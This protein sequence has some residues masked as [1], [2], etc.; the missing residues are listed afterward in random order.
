MLLATA[1]H[2]AMLVYLDNALS[3]SPKAR[4]VIPGAQPGINE[5]YA[6]ELLELHTMGVDGGYSQRDVEEVARCF[7][8]WTIDRET[9]VYR[10]DVTLHDPGAKTVLGTT[11][12]DGGIEEGIRV[13]Q[14]LASHLSTAKFIAGKLARRFVADQPP[15]SLVEH[16][17]G[18]F[19]RTSGDIREVC[20]TILSSEEFFAPGVF[21][22]KV[23]SPFE[24][25]VS[26]VRAIDA[27]VLVPRRTGISELVRVM[28]AATPAAMEAAARERAIALEA[29]RRRA[30][31]ATGLSASIQAYTHVIEPMH[32]MGQ[33]P[34]QVSSPKGYPETGEDWLNALTS[35]N[36]MTFGISLAENRLAGMEFGNAEMKKLAGSRPPTS[37]EG[38]LGILTGLPGTQPLHSNPA[39]VPASAVNPSTSR[40]FALA[41]GSPDF[42]YK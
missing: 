10:F 2:P 20:R 7:T 26:S 15:A 3:S 12:P 14:L 36:R 42:Q 25:V 16:A 9:L 17:A 13:V 8:G 40:M 22:R 28:N 1:E 27:T 37:W 11:I 38:A 32:T 41:L 19:S 21:R 24:L 35:L 18:V 23:K 6:R 29:D 30:R 34:Y 39:K 31:Y 4:P 33:M 5:N